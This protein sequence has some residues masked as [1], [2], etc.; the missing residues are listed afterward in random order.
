M[1]PSITLPK[2]SKH[3][4]LSH[5][6]NIQKEWKKTYYTPWVSVSLILWWLV[7]GTILRWLVQATM[8]RIWSA[9]EL[10]RMRKALFM[11]PHD[12]SKRWNFAQCKSH[13]MDLISYS[14]YHENKEFSWSKLP[15]THK[16]SCLKGNLSCLVFNKLCWVIF[17]FLNSI[18]WKVIYQ[19]WPSTASHSPNYRLYYQ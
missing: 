19:A 14:Y 5:K 4:L 17:N 18:A 16:I 15:K 9:L 3:H 6:A 10:N 12:H 11:D 2:L 1:I 8:I 7:Q 13:T